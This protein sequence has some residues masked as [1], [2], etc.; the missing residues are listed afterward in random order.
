MTCSICFIDKMGIGICDLE[1]L[2]KEELRQFINS[3]IIDC[4]KCPFKKQFTGKEHL[5]FIYTAWTGSI[6]E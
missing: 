1:K 6:S 4:N 2:S 5:H 3:D